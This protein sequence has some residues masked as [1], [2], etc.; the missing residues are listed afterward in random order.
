M[1]QY[2]TGSSAIP[3]SDCDR[4]LCYSE[5]LMLGWELMGICLAFFPPSLKFYSYLEG[6]I[7]RHLDPN[8]DTEKVSDSRREPVA[9]KRSMSLNRTDI[10]NFLDYQ[11]FNPHYTK[12]VLGKRFRLKASGL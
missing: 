7:Y 6:F 4:A 1:C 2:S 8:S 9:Q 10:I 12:V 3:D 5:S 11:Y